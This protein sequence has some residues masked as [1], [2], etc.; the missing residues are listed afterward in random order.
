MMRHGICALFAFL[1]ACSSVDNTAV[2]TR[3]PVAPK[4]YT[5]PAPR[6]TAPVYTPAKRHLR[7]F[8]LPPGE[9]SVMSK[10][11]LERD[12]RRS[13][14]GERQYLNTEIQ[15]LERRTRFDDDDVRAVD[16]Q[17]LRDLKVRQRRVIRRLRGG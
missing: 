15:T 9:P 16:E 13:L 14:Q 10:T 5:V 3:G 7:P 6:E 17:R 11:P 4:T 12:E 1:A 2:W 8:R